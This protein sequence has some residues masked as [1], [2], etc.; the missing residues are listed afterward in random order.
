[1]AIDFLAGVARFWWPWALNLTSCWFW[2]LS[3]LPFYYQVSWKWGFDDRISSNWSKV[4]GELDQNSAL[5]LI[6]FELDYWLTIDFLTGLARFWWPRAHVGFDFWVTYYLI[7]S[8]KRF[9]NMDLIRC[10]LGFGLLVWVLG[11]IGLIQFQF[12]THK[13]ELAQVR[14][15]LFS[16]TATISWKRF[17]Q[18]SQ[19]AIGDH[20]EKRSR[21]KRC[22]DR[23]KEQA[24]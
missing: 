12:Q 7:H 14:Y 13:L 8:L 10:N 18:H 15:F 5:E 4:F 20:W 2:F 16:T 9:N 22:N 6:D 1:M 24:G 19:Q 11:F 3:Y 23:F 21:D 17:S